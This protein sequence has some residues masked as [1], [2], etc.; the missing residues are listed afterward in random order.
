M[1]AMKTSARWI[2]HDWTG[3]R[4]F[5]DKEFKSFE[6]GWEHIRTTHPDENDWQEFSVD[7]KEG[8]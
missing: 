5:P 7:P 2:I 4:I 6:D 1:P 3:R 8:E